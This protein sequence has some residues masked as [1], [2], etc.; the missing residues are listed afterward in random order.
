MRDLSS[1]KLALSFATA[2]LVLL[3]TGCASSPPPEISQAGPTAATSTP[4]TVSPSAAATATAT[5]E[6]SFETDTYG[7]R[8][9]N[10]E[11]DRSA[12]S[13]EEGA[14]GMTVAD[15][16]LWVEE[17]FLISQCMREKGIEYRFRLPWQL[18]PDDQSEANEQFS[19]DELLALYGEPAPTGPY[20]WTQ[21]GC[22]G[23]AEHE[24]SLSGTT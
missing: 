18:H 15:Q 23:F 11:S 5:P 14:L 9:W 7:V 8:F 17:K 22:S 24:M 19:E 20:D 2:T 16:Q 3:L 21:H 1:L 12:V 10:S 4:Q 6:G 13:Y